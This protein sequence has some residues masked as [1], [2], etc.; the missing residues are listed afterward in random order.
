MQCITVLETV[1]HECASLH[2]A[3]RVSSIWSSKTCAAAAGPGCVAWQGGF[4]SEMT[5]REAALILGLRESAP[6]DKVK[7]RYVQAMLQQAHASVR[8]MMALVRVVHFRSPLGICACLPWLMTSC[9]MRT[10]AS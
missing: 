5:R 9:R 6:E 4:Q 10:A 8:W 7:V 2:I 1:C 3:F